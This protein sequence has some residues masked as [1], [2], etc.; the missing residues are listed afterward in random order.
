MDTGHKDS[1]Q[2]TEDIG[3][4]GATAPRVSLKDIEAAIAKTNYVV[5]GKAVRALGQACDGAGDPLNL[6]TLCLVTMTNG[7]VI[8]GKSAPASPENF[9]A[10][11]GRTFAREDAIRQIWPLMGFALRDRLGEVQREL[12]PA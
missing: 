9:D 2:A 12:E 5:A 3:A 7:F 11:K 6:L 4:R 10:E 8:V 1:L